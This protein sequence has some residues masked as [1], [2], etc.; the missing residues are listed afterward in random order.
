MPQYLIHSATLVS[1]ADAIREK[2]GSSDPI[3]VT[4][5]PEA[6]RSLSGDTSSTLPP[7]VTDVT[8]TGGD[9]SMTIAF[10]PVSPEYE[11]LL[12]DPAYVIVLKEGSAPQSPTDGTVIS[13]DKTGAVVV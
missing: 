12:G 8:A 9:R 11:A 10:A 4:A 1:I 7:P 6:I 13:L 3:A 2:T 5:M